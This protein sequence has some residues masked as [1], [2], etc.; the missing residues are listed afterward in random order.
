[1]HSYEVILSVVQKFLY[2]FLQDSN[3]IFFD[4]V[5][6]VELLQLQVCLTDFLHH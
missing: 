5:N 3:L 2:L 4:F 6:F 1:M